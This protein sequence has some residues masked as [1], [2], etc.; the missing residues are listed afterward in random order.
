MELPHPLKGAFDRVDRAQEHMAEL[1]REVA[2]HG[3][4]HHDACTIAFD[5]Q[6]SNALTCIH[7]VQ[8]P[9]IPSRISILTGE[10]VYNLRAA[11]DYLVFELAKLDSG[12]EQE[13]TQFLIRDTQ[14]QF[15]KDRTSAL[16][17]LNAVHVAR[18]DGLQPYRGVYWTDWLQQISNADKHRKLTHHGSGSGSMVL[19]PNIPPQTPTDWGLSQNEFIS[20]RRA[21]GPS[22]V[23][24][25][26]QLVTTM[27][28]HVPIKKFGSPALVLVGQ[29]L[30][31]TLH[32][33]ALG[34]RST[35]DAFEP[36]FLGRS[37]LRRYDPQTGF[38]CEGANSMQKDDDSKSRE[39]KIERGTQIRDSDRRITRE[40]K[41]APAKERGQPPP[42]EKDR[43]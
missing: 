15:A 29:P 8:F 37:P 2:S 11:L 6:F 32:K 26:V 33:I 43:R 20:K 7:P 22:G 31:E 39:Q 1:K 25:D 38:R 23:E 24:I 42:R 21:I 12:V 17:G 16:K 9:R 19:P 30:E 27:M 5:P 4:C 10:I 35:L 34:V 18:I 14:K 40:P 3:Q 13:R 41:Q 28:L 36:E